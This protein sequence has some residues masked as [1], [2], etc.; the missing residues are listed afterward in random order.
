MVLASATIFW[1]SS[2]PL[3]KFLFFRNDVHYK[4]NIFRS[5]TETFQMELLPQELKASIEGIIKSCPDS[6]SVFQ[7]LVAHYEP[8]QRKLAKTFTCVV[9]GEKLNKLPTDLCKIQSAKKRKLLFT[10]GKVQRMFTVEDSMEE[11]ALEWS[12]LEEIALM[13]SGKMYLCDCGI[14][15]YYKKNSFAFK[16]EDLKTIQIV[17]MTTHHCT[18]AVNGKNA[19]YF[20]LDMVDLVQNYCAQ[21]GK[22]LTM[23]NAGKKEKRVLDELMEDASDDDGEDDEDTEDEFKGPAGD[24]SD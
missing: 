16:V 21:A 22:E 4:I 10:A 9:T 8:L 11:T 12:V 20:P 1:G 23:P 24:E 13:H 7:S 5:A 14:A 17:E 3:N 15:L 18:I 2:C 6:K 19:E